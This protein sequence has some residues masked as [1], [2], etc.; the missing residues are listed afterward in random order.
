MNNRVEFEFKILCGGSVPCNLY[1]KKY[2]INFTGCH[3]IQKIIMKNHIVYSNISYGASH[4]H[5]KLELEKHI[6]E[7]LNRGLISRLDKVK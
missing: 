2:I 3:D 5:T 6:K 7:N 1:S 4:Y